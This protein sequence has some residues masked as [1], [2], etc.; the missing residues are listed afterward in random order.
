MAET[1]AGVLRQAED[2]H[3]S[4]LLKINIAYLAMTGTLPDKGGQLYQD[5]QLLFKLRNLIVHARPEEVEFGESEKP[6]EYPKIV[7]SF[8]SRRVIEMPKSGSAIAWQQYVIVPPVALWAYNTSISAMKWLAA[9]AP[10]RWLRDFLQFQTEELEE[11]D[12]TGSTA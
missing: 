1:V 3:A 7:R 6:A 2:G 10:E 5:I 4:I 9:S 12:K 8:A 11:I